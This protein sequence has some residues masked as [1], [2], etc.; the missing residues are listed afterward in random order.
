MTW[1]TSSMEHPCFRNL[2]F[3]LVTIN[4]SWIQ[5]A[6][7]FA[8]HKGLRRYARLNFGINSASEIFQ[9]IIKELIRDIPG[10]LDISDDVVVF[11]KMQVEHNKALHAVCQKFTAEVNLTLNHE[12]WEYN[13]SLITFFGFVF[14]SKGIL[15][16]SSKVEAIN[17]ASPPT[18]VSGVWSFL[19]MATS[20]SSSSQSSVTSHNHCENWWKKYTI[21]VDRAAWAVIQQD[22]LRSCSPATPLWHTLIL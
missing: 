1:S 18:S 8:T 4:S 12:K 7:T 2:T 16:D 9:N 10:A 3:D 5:R 11:G 15:S 19:G 22:Q 14:S 17:T 20:C 21:P 13:N 6:V